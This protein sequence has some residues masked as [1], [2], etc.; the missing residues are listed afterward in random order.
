MKKKKQHNLKRSGR[1][2][3][4]FLNVIAIIVA[5]ITMVVLVIAVTK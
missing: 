3:L 4:S 1:E 2:S 5:I